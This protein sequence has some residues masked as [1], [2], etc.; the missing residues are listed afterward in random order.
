MST[1]SK[2]GSDP[3]A[4]EKKAAV[5]KAAAEELSVVDQRKA[6][7][8]R[9]SLVRLLLLLLPSPSNKLALFPYVVLVYSYMFDK[10]LASDHVCFLLIDHNCVSPIYLHLRSADNFDMLFTHLCIQL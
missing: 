2:A 10:K 3:V 9:R 6:W 5:A 7:W 4:L 1:N 8:I